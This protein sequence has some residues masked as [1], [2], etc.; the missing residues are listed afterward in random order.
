M[1]VVVASKNPVKIQACRE[2]FEKQFPGEAIETVGLAAESG[3]NDQ[4]LSDNETRQGAINRSH[5][6][7]ELQPNADYWVGLEG[8][9]DTFDGQLMTFAWMSVLG[10]NG[11]SSAARTVTLP[12]PPA[13]KELVEA[14]LLERY[15]TKQHPRSIYTSLPELN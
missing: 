10:A 12:L 1:K 13:V 7:R 14:G 11:H 4:P 5:N 6:A 8:G 3:V 2:A 9:V 15:D